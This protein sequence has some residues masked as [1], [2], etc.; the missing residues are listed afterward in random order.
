MDPAEGNFMLTESVCVT[1]KGAGGNPLAMKMAETLVRTARPGILKVY[2]VPLYEGENFRED[3]RSSNVK[4][5]PEPLTVELL[6]RHQAL[7][8]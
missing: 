2:P 3:A 5:F 6:K 1:D 7:M 4:A 8:N